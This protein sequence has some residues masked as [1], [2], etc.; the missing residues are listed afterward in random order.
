[1]GKEDM[2]DE[3]YLPDNLEACQRQLSETRRKVEETEDKYLRAAAE[4]ENVRK[5]TER[6]VLARAKEDQRTQLHLFL[7]VMDNLERALSQPAES[8]TLYR[9]VELTMLQLKKALA[10]AG[11]E[12]IQVEP[13]DSFDPAYQEGVGVRYGEVDEPEIGEVVQT[14]YLYEN[15]LLRPA[16]VV[17]IKPRD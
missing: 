8:I 13:G 15:E 3:L 4:V 14:G 10:S 12:R 2:E 9:G 17:V 6:N 16:R 7:D 5:W 1:M 11:V